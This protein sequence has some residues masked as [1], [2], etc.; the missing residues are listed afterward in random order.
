[1]PKGRKSPRSAEQTEFLESHLAEFMELQPRL[2]TFWVKVEKG[3]F[4][5]WKVED[6]LN[7]PTLGDGIEDCELSEEQQTMIGTAQAKMKQVRIPCLR[8]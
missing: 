4:Q 5:K 1:M 3:W 7:L 6:D 2:T 8:Y